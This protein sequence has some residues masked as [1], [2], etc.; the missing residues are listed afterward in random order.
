MMKDEREQPSAAQRSQ[1]FHLNQRLRGKYV[2][3]T[4][5][6]SFYFELRGAPHDPELDKFPFRMGGRISSVTPLG[7]LLVDIDAYEDAGGS[8]LPLSLG[9]RAIPADKVKRIDL[10]SRLS[11]GDPYAPFRYRVGDEVVR[12]REGGLPDPEMHGVI[13]DGT[14]EYQHGDGSYRAPVYEV[15]LAGTDHSFQAQELELARR[16]LP[17]E[18]VREAG[19]II[20]S[21]L[22][23]ENKGGG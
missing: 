13:V 9:I 10:V 3:V 2:W 20:R 1:A 11:A 8:R 4:V 6:A 19:R 7:G 14:V 21:W 5:P 17:F 12:V 22:R 18:N 15:Q 16:E 23:P